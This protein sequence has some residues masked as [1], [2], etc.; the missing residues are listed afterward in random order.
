MDAIVVDGLEKTYGKDVRALDGMPLL[1]PGGRG[2]R[3]ARPERRRQVDDGAR[4]SSTLTQA[5]AGRAVGGRARRRAEAGAVRRAI[6]YVPQ[7]SG[8]D[9]E[10]TGRENLLLQGRLQGMRGADLERRA[11]TSCSRPSGWATRRTRSSGPTR[12]A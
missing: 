6:G 11:P 8:V 10:A 4:S 7:A 9:R 1:G 2:L 5:D 12:A 3:S